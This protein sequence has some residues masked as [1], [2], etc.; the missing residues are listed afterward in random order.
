MSD[1]NSMSEIV[2]RDRSIMFSYS[3]NLMDTRR[4]G[5]RDKDGWFSINCLCSCLLSL[6]LPYISREVLIS[7]FKFF[8]ES[9]IQ[10]HFFKYEA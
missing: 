5:E 8:I 1:R 3:K 9:G 7:D 4:K 10:E 2:V 6:S